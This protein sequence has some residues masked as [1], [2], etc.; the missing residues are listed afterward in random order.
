M[1]VPRRH[2]GSAVPDPIT[3][4]APAGTG[5]GRLAELVTADPHARVH[6]LA[7]G[8]LLDSALTYRHVVTAQGLGADSA[9]AAATCQLYARQ[10]AG[11]PAVDDVAAVLHSLHQVRS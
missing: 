7:A 4:P 6:E 3:T 1:P 9:I 11:T 8:A 10:H 5:L 2:P